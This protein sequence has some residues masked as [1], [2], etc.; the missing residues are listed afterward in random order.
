[1]QKKQKT[2]KKI[3]ISDSEL[4]LAINQIKEFVTLNLL[5]PFFSKGQMFL[6]FF[7]TKDAF[8][9]ILAGKHAPSVFAQTCGDL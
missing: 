2:A 3:N 9:P 4:L 7:C 6:V 5:T 8:R 1:M